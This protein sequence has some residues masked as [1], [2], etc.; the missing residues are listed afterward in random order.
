[1]LVDFLA[2][3]QP[4]CAGTD[5]FCFFLFGQG[6][7]SCRKKA[8]G[9]H[10]VCVHTGPNTL[11]LL[12]SGNRI[13]CRLCVHS[14][15]GEFSPCPLKGVD[16]EIIFVNLCIFGFTPPLLGYWLLRGTP[17]HVCVQTPDAGACCQLSGD[18]GPVE[19]VLLL[20]SF[21]TNRPALHGRL[22]EM[23][24]LVDTSVYQVLDL[25][26]APPLLL[27]R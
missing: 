5:S 26:S 2:C 17:L 23:C 14:V 22:L 4:F 8:G 24:Q 27:Y 12:C 6:R 10:G 1:M 20:P 21:Q 25:L 19:R 7:S 16:F 18:C 9:G 3:V 13:L 15:A 11:Q